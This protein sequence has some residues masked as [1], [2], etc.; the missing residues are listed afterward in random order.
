[1]AVKRFIKLIA[2]V[3]VVVAQKSTIAYCQRLEEEIPL[4]G[5]VKS[6]WFEVYADGKT[7]VI[8]A[9]LSRTS[10]YYYIS[11]GTD[12]SFDKSLAIGVVRNSDGEILSGEVFIVGSDR[13][14][15]EANTGL[16][17]EIS[18]LK[19]EREELRKRLEEITHKKD[20]VYLKNLED[21]GLWE[22]VG[23]A[24]QIKQLRE[25]LSN[26]KNIHSKIEEFL[27]EAKKGE[28]P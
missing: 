9:G 14:N 1:M 17:R 26:Y 10:R 12:K 22:L 27:K 8:P 19:K 25:K 15:E 6:Q 16:W 3:V 28:E 2:A 18:R 13:T 24:R 11:A 21:A 7:N 4:K 5:E 20:E 23:I